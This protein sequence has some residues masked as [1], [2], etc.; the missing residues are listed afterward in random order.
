[1]DENNKIDNGQNSDIRFD[2]E[3]IVQVVSADSAKKK[4]NMVPVII[5]AAVLVVAIVCGVVWFFVG[6]GKNGNSGAVEEHGSDIHEHVNSGDAL[7]EYI[8]ENIDADL[9][10]EEGNSI[11]REEYI[12]RLEAM[13]NEAT[14]TV[15]ENVGNFNPNTIVEITT[16][17]DNKDAADDNKQDDNKQDE[18]QAEKAEKAIK[19]FFDRSCYMKGAMYVGYEGNALVMSMD[20]DDFEVLTNL[21]GT[22]VSILNLDG[23]MYIKRPATKQYLELTDTVMDLV[24]IDASNFSMGFNTADYN[25][26]KKK[27]TGVYKVSYNNQ[28]AFCHE[29]KNDEQI[30][31]FYTVEGS[32][33]EIDICDVDG[34]VTTQLVIDY[35]SEAIPGDQLTLKG[36]TASSITVIFADMM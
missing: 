31:K 32:L 6:N 27:L 22:E 16:A 15:S 36:Y 19:M 25:K 20:G 9:V 29:Y 7:L 3:N 14:T 8:E 24:G 26:M 33:K 1:M 21:D 17:A 30:F 2:V 10:D 23:K 34:K 5:A 18:A 4:K 12:S 35:F 28:D 13:V 11:S